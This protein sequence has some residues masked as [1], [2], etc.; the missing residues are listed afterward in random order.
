M[1]IVPKI[2]VYKIIYTICSNELPRKKTLGKFRHS[3][4]RKIMSELRMRCRQMGLNGLKNE[5]FIIAE[6][7]SAAEDL[8]RKKP[9]IPWRSYVKIES[10]EML[11]FQ[12]TIT[13]EVE[14]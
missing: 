2:Q 9:R 12:Q 13:S 6:S 10:T 8:F 7:E 5:I 11:D 4:E 3:N 1:T 14:K